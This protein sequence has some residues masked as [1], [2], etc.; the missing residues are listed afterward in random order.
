MCKEFVN[1][2]FQMNVIHRDLKPENILLDYDGHIVVSDYGFCKK[3]PD[4]EVN[5][6]SIL[7]FVEFT[8]TGIKAGNVRAMLTAVCQ[9][10][11]FTYLREVKIQ[12][13]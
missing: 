1:F 8:Y 11:L 3:F 12:E 7:Y 4:T 5:F 10:V 13:P 6:L 2:F 9:A